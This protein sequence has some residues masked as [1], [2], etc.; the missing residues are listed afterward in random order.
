MIFGLSFVFFLIVF[1]GVFMFIANMGNESTHSSKS[2]N[3]LTHQIVNQA[4]QK[5]SNQLSHI[6][7]AGIIKKY[8]SFYIIFSIFIAI[9]LFIFSTNIII[10]FLVIS[11]LLILPFFVIKL[12]QKR[13]L[14]LFEK[15]LPD[16]IDLM[17]G[18]LKSGGSLTNALAM[19]AE[20]FP[21]PL[22][23]EIGL[24]I[25]EQKLGVNIDTSLQNFSQRMPYDSVILTVSAIR[26]SVQTGGELSD[27]L[28]NIAITLRSIEQAEGKIKAL[29]AQGKMQAW[30][31]GLMPVLLIIALNKME[32]AAMSQLWTTTVGYI[33]LAVIVILE[34]LGIIFIRKIVNIDV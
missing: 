30:V 10:I 14:A 24:I 28:K 6:S 2:K 3:T 29:T 31:V 27:A 18:A 33:A 13:R 8:I 15:Q 21:K 19:I 1:I 20:E 7:I 16:A 22:S 4:T 23:D 11:S 32:P 12:I 25:R 17:A 5:I 34:I 26:V 9:S